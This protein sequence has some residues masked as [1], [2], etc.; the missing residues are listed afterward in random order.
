[1]GLKL[2]KPE[3]GRDIR[4]N[5]L[6]YGL[7][8]V[9]KTRLLGTAQDC[10]Y[11]SPIFYIAVESGTVTLSG[12]NIDIFRPHSYADIQEAY[13]FLRYENTTYK[14]VGFDSL[15]ED[16]RKLSM[17]EITGTLEGET[18]YRNLADHTPPSRYDWLASSGQMRRTIM[19]FRD[20]AYLPNK[21]RRIHVFFTALEKRDE[22]RNIVCPALPGVLGLDV[23][24]SVDVL[25]RMSIERIERN[26][27][28][29]RYRKLS[30][31]EVVGDDGITYMGKARTPE[32]STLPNTM[33][34]PTIAKLLEYWLGAPAQETPI[35]KRIRSSTK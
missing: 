34:Q 25:A 35:R 1:M 20:L 15:T 2:T 10:E 13:D 12:K 9:G 18:S 7:T 6:I 24:A 17:G 31:Q 33:F 22:E 3:I 26:D 4:L 8:G 27:K 21:R 29:K 5:M 32:S 28:V 11:T 19:A 30:F 14:S 23:G 16:Q